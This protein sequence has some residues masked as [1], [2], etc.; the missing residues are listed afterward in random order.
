MRVS[1]AYILSHSGLGDNV[2]MISCIHFLAN[3]YDDVYY[4]CRCDHCKQ[5]EYVYK[6]FPFIHIVP[7]PLVNS[8]ES[9]DENKSFLL[10]KYENSDIF[11]CGNHRCYL[12]SKITHPYLLDYSLLYKDFPQGF[13]S[14]MREPYKNIFPNIDNY[15]KYH[16]DGIDIINICLIF[17][18]L[19]VIFTITLI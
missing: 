15:Y 16:Y 4:L 19:L 2:V 5:M 7:I 18:I 6:P 17:S 10:P 12:N 3:F 9:N 11:I 13:Q 8:G 14:F 1:S